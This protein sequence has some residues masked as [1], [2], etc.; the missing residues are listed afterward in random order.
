MGKMVSNRSAWKSLEEERIIGRQHRIHYS[1]GNEKIMCGTKKWQCSDDNW[2]NVECKL[3]LA[4]KEIFTNLK[5]N[6]VKE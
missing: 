2:E 5:L 6:E 1:I 4:K 3:C